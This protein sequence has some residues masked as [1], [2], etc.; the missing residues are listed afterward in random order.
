MSLV[1]DTREGAD[2]SSQF[3][4]RMRGTGVW[5]QLLRDRFKLASRRL[6]LSSERRIELAT[7]HF[8][9]PERGGQMGLGF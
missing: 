8:R 6:G 5:A 4:A 2:N 1:N 7:H 9:P 3:G